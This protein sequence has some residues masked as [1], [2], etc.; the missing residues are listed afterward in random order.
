MT[1]GRYRNRRALV[2][3]GLG[4]LG[5]NLT[6][7]LLREGAEVTVVDALVEGCGGD[8]ANLGPARASVTLCHSN[9][10]D[11]RAMAD[12]LPGTEVIFNLAGEVSH[13]RSVQD[14]ERDLELNARAHLRFLEACRRWAP[15]ARIVYTSTRQV[16]G[17][18]RYLP[19]DEEHPTAVVDF[20]GVHKLAAESY[21]RLLSSLYGLPTVCLRLTNVYGP[22]QAL[23]LPSQGFI[24]VFLARVLT[25]EDVCVYGDGTQLRDLLYVDDAVEALLRAGLAPLPAGSSHATWNVGGPRALQLADIARVVAG[26]R[27]RQVPFPEDLLPIDIGSY[28]TDDR[29]FRAWTG[30]APRVELPEGIARTLAYYRAY[31]CPENHPADRPSGASPTVLGTISP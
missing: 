4:F 2:T 13:V 11:T 18:P 19:V 7:A 22:R 24:A 29:R 14:P 16:Y 5:S 23:H 10:A 28:C 15:Q 1:G 25:G 6:L 8:E 17:R 30:W 31:V 27:V 20:N 3:G 26:S 21:H 12:V 9:I